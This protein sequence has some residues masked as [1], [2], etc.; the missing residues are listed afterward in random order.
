MSKP[1]TIN[2]ELVQKDASPEPYAI[3]D[4]VR[5]QDAEA[6]AASMRAHLAETRAVISLTLAESGQA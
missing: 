2:F 6:A 1:K 3:L 5:R 4:A